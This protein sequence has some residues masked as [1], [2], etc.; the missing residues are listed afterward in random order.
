MSQT[1]NVFDTFFEAIEGTL[2]L[3][4]VVKKIIECGPG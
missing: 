4:N 2:M 1:P 3:I